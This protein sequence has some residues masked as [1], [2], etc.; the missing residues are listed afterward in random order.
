MKTPPRLVVL[1]SGNGSNLQAIIDACQS[2]Q[3]DA[4][5]AGVIS[6]RA[7][8]YGLTRAAQAG[9]STQLVDH[10]NFAD[11]ESFDQALIS[12]I[13]SLQPDIVVLAGFMRILTPLFVQHYHNR[14]LNI[15]PSLLPRHKGLHTHQR[16]LDAG[17]S[18]HG[19]SVHLVSAELDDGPLLAQAVLAIQP[20][21]NSERLAQRVH[22]LE[23]RLYPAVLQAIASGALSLDD[24]RHHNRPLPASGLRLATQGLA[25][26]E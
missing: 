21:E 18:H 11:R 3:L 10:K 23:H 24:R 4:H 7:D 13:D 5:L 9:I 8:A 14:L 6:N 15:H 25:L 19:A 2:G 22:A 1:L 12:T 17:D 26:Q 20:G 16:A